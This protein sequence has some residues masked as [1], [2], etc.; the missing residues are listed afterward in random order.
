VAGVPIPKHAIFGGVP[1]DGIMGREFGNVVPVRKIQT[2]W[3]TSEDTGTTAQIYSSNSAAATGKGRI[4][5]TS[6]NL[7]PNLGRD[8]LAE[9]LLHNLV[10]YAQDALP[11]ELE[12]EDT[13]MT[14]R[15]K[16][17]LASYHDCVTKYLNKKRKARAV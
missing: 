11:R 4:I 13:E 5:I 3:N 7:L 14:E 6:L 16:F 15:L 17:Q 1:P 10:L 9:K 2:D 12:P 8:A